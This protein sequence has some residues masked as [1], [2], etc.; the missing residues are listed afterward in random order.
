MSTGFV[1][2][3]ACKR[4][5]HQ[6]GSHHTWLHCEDG[7]PRCEG[8]VSIYPTAWWDIKGTYCEAD[9]PA[10]KRP[11]PVLSDEEYFSRGGR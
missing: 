10:P 2:C 3:M 8:A 7:T 1:V 9:G 5:V 11:S 4:E 6:T